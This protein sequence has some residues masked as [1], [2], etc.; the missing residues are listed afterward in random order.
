MK[1]SL[2]ILLFIS[3]VV[4]IY[5]CGGDSITV[6]GPTPTAFAGLPIITGFTPSEGTEGTS[7]T[8]KGSNFSSSG[9]VTV[10][11]NGISLTCNSLNSTELVF[12]LPAGAATGKIGVTTGSGTGYSENNFIVTDSS[13]NM[14]LIPAGT[15]Y[16]GYCNAKGWDE[17]KPR[18]KVEISYNFYVS[19]Y[20][21]TNK[22]YTVY[23]PMHW[24][25]GLFSDNYYPV[26]TVTWNEAVSYCNWLTERT[27]ELGRSQVCYDSS[28]NLD[29]TKKGYRLPTEAEWEY[30]CRADNMANYYWGNIMDASK[31]LYNANSPVSAGYGGG[32]PWGLYDMSGN[33][34][35]WC[36]DWYG[37]YSGEDQ[38]N[39]A[40]P[41]SGSDRVLRGGCWVYDD[42]DELRSASRYYYPPTMGNGMSGFR[43][44]RTQ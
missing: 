19:K 23:E 4:V 30:A 10:T 17:E 36:N 5:G 37:N 25:R 3:L 14:V 18:H 27:P 31:C 43:I 8:I 28:R 2:Y 11:F 16:M 24:T 21:V 40:G 9:P 42:A 13:G 41:A 39:P 22:E 38:K 44:V 1:K 12:I 7:V 20:E 15:F 35:E 34:S 29:I 26:E 6:P 32:H 33:I